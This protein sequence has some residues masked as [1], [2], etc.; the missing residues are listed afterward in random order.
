MEVTLRVPAS[1]RQLAEGRSVTVVELSAGATV[2]DLLDALARDQPALERRIRDEQ[3]VLRPHVNLFV[4]DEDIRSL[5]G[6]GTLLRSGDDVSV[7]AA[8]SGG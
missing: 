5:D 4:G 2:A 7:V 3:G 1:L 6:A 8:I